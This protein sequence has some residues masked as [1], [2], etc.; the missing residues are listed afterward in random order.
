MT[1]VIQIGSRVTL[2]YSLTL[3]DGQ[4]VDSTRTSGPASIVIGD[5]EM[6]EFLEQRLLGLRA[7]E[8]RHFELSAHDTQL[9]VDVE[10]VQ[11]VPRSDFPV[12]IEPVTGKVIGFETPNG[13]EIAGLVLSVTDE[14]VLLDFSHP[15]AGRDLVFD[16][17]ILAVESA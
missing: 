17:E 15:L 16:V 8:Q 11:H 2:H 13:E 7:G 10:T 12:G 3:Q 5:G 14:E 6:V 1:D 4:P 9:P